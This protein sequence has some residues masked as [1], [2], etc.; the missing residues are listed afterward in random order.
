MKPGDALIAALRGRDVID[1]ADARLV[2]W[3]RDRVPDDSHTG[4]RETFTL[5][6]ATLCRVCASG[7]LCLPLA[8]EPLTAALAETIGLASQAA[9][10]SGVPHGD[11]AQ[12]AAGFLAALEDG[13]DTDTPFAAVFATLIGTGDAPRPLVRDAG[14]LYF[15][16]FWFAAR[17]LA[18]AFRER[19]T[20]PPP[21]V[22][23][24]RE[25]ILHET[26]VTRRL[27]TADGVPLDLTDG[28]KTALVTALSSS[29]FVLAGGPGTGKTTWTAA[30]LRAV[31][32]LPGT[33]ATRVR[34]C[35]PT[36]RAAQRLTESLRATLAGN[37]DDPRDAA[38]AGLQAT[39]L[40]TLLGW[41]AFE[42]RFARCPE[43]PLEADWVLLDEASM[44]D[45]FL[46]TALVRALK[47]G[48]RLVLAGDPGQLPAVEAAAVLGELL[49]DPEEATGP[50]ASHILDV[51]HRST[52]E[53]IPLSSAVRRGQDDDVIRLLGP[54]YTAATATGAFRAF[55]P[56]EAA[57]PGV[58]S[59]IEPGEN[60]AA[61][62]QE[63][64]FAYA[65]AAFG[66]A[67]GYTTL[68]DRFR[69]A[70]RA[71][72]GALTRALWAIAARTRVLAPL[73]RGP[74]SAERANRILRDRLASAWRRPRDAHGPGFH[75]APILITRNDARTGL[76]NG[77]LGLW[78][79]AG[80]GATVYFPRP[81]HADGWLRIPIALLPSCELG[82]ATTVHKSQG[83]ECDEV[84]VI[85]PEAG[86][87]LLARETLY[88]AI[89][90]A[91]TVVCLYGS[92]EAVREATQR[93]LRRPG[94]LRE[95][96]I[97]A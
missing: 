95:L 67:S 11:A 57:R 34:L 76:A 9:P 62:L 70:T 41:R 92:E 24:V 54:A 21:A 69:A 44:A 53:V 18:E 64:L 89:T 5:V 33:D 32:R 45:I 46:L 49:P 68:L 23:P 56:L 27:R 37:L 22:P 79:E 43:D 13:A 12:A 58:L 61:A 60:P 16:R 36:G 52:G 51:S 96:L 30:W 81:G 2:M 26:L 25:A 65:A 28:Q 93:T 4:L 77:D 72:E 48:T 73:R 78:L 55:Q 6:V 94:G 85:L 1:G 66:T 71:E 83:S 84:L 40:H 91:R 29:V 31:L 42:G 14:N 87:R 50:V 74:V 38:A 86:N 80:D 59:R 35:A 75:G 97:N 19:A 10:E 90:R 15:H 17:T 47:P 7:S 39:T 63:I 20:L 88:T 8:R 3:L 82:F